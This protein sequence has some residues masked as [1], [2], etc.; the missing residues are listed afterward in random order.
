MFFQFRLFLEENFFK[1][2]FVKHHLLHTLNMSSSGATD[3]AFTQ[4][5]FST[6][7][8]NFIEIIVK[9]FTKI[10]YIFFHKC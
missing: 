9:I 7:N 4:I 10:P 3:G 8:Q 5:N 1:Q 6:E 2:Q